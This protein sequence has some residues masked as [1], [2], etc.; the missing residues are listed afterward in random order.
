[1]KRTITIIISIFILLSFVVPAIAA[2]NSSESFPYFD[3]LEVVKDQTVTIQA[4]NFP[5]NDT[6]T[7]TM[8]AYGTYGIGGIEAGETDSGAGG[9]F[10]VTYNIPTS[11]NGAE[12]IAIRLYSPT[13]G[14]YAYNWFW[15]N[16]SSIPSGTPIASYSGFPTFSIESVVMDQSVTILTNNLPPQDTFTVTM[17][18]FGTQGVDGVVVGTTDS[19]VG[20][21]LELTYNIPTELSGLDLIAIRLQSPVTGYYAYNWFY[22]NTTTGSSTQQPAPNATPSPS[23]YSGYPTFLIVTVLKDSTVSIEGENFPPQDTFTVLMGDYGTLGVGGIDVG[24]TQTGEGGS[25]TATYNIP[26]SLAGSSRIAIRL[27]SPTS[28][29]F[30][31]NW[32]YNNTAP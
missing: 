16:T 25:L 13:S 23:G 21:S 19:G 31:Y 6:F 15:N 26:S 20:G 18:N 1:M 5:A 30:A 32:F 17:G 24:S 10:T 11:L 28:G 7:V 9:S 8:G 29:Y 22:N 14:Y 2:T 27:Q 12:R 3:I 4:Y